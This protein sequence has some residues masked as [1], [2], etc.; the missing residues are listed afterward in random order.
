MDQN[1]LYLCSELVSL[2]G[3][4]TETVGNLEMIGSRECSVAVPESI[5]PGTPVK[6]ACLE[7]PRGKRRCSECRFEARVKY[8]EAGPEG[9]SVRIEFEKR[10]WTPGEWRPR[11]L[12]EFPVTETQ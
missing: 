12:A 1:T 5:A 7:C 4:T 9:P 6:M 10:R 8:V 2:L 3:P 11:H